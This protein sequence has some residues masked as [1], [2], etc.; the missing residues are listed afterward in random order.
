MHDTPDN[1]SWIRDEHLI[2]FCTFFSI[3]IVLSGHRTWQ[4]YRSKTARRARIHRLLE[5]SRREKER[6]ELKLA[7]SSDALNNAR[8][9]ERPKPLASTKPPPP[10]ASASSSTPKPESEIAT[11]PL[12]DFSQDDSTP[13]P[14]IAKRSKERRKRGRDVCKDVLRQGRSKASALP[15][16]SVVK[17]TALL[18][19]QT[20][21][22][23]D[24]SR[25]RSREDNSRSSSRAG[26]T[27]DSDST[28]ETPRP[29]SAGWTDRNEECSNVDSQPYAT[30]SN[31]THAANNERA[32]PCHADLSH[33]DTPPL[34]RSGPSTSS[35][36]SISSV[37]I[38]AGSPPPSPSIQTS[39]VEFIVENGETSISITQP[40]P[41][42]S[43]D[44]SQ[45]TWL[46][47]SKRLPETFSFGSG[48]S[49]SASDASW[50]GKSSKHERHDKSQSPNR[51]HI[52][53]RFSNISLPISAS[54]SDSSPSSTPPPHGVLKAQLRA[55][56]NALESSQRKEENYSKEIER[57]HQ[58]C[59]MIR[60]QW[61][62]DMERAHL[63]ELEV[64]T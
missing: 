56:R 62:E 52:H 34:T 33:T 12:V 24:I 25:S 44:E 36:A 55:Y 32:G 48:S 61:E 46:D 9:Q 40:T 50:D 57:L 10:E 15:P 23:S 54:L 13:Q 35:S 27:S 19:V 43:H 5:T 39:N 31:L 16:P 41:L 58:E 1:N 28:E 20:T 53:S 60:H 42:D 8:H 63:Q 17:P 45:H 49:L 51:A 59:N 6:T 11:S 29:R 47:A 21:S 30:E 14:T 38:S 4:N 18:Q 22:E 3:A 26:P 7:L 64:S 37:S 2:F